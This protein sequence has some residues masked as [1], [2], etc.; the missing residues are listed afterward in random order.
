[1]SERGHVRDVVGFGV[2]GTDRGDAIVGG[3]AG[4]GHSIVA[5]VKVLALLEMC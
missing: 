2:L 4:F 1:M 5:G 3:F